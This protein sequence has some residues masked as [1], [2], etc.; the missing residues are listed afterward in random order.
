MA[1]IGRAD[2]IANDADAERTGAAERASASDGASAS[3]DRAGV[4]IDE[5]AARLAGQ[6]P[7]QAELLGE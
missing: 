6:T 1:A 7:S 3:A 5:Q 2:G 4:A